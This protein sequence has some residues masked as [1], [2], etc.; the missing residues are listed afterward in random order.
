[1]M[2]HPIQRRLI[3]SPTYLNLT[4]CGRTFFDR[5]N[6]SSSIFILNILSILS[7]KWKF[8][9]FQVKLNM[10]QNHNGRVPFENYKDLLTKFLT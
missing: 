3:S 5:I 10:T 4:P 2:H 1:M 8:L 7:K 9:Y 6:R